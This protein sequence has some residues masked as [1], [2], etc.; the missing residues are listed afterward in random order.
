MEWTSVSNI[1]TGSLFFVA[2]HTPKFTKDGFDGLSSS[3]HPATRTTFD[4]QQDTPPELTK[5]IRTD[6]LQIAHVV[7]CVTVALTDLHSQSFG[8]PNLFPHNEDASNP[9]GTVKR[10]NDYCYNVHNI[11]FDPEGCTWDAMVT[12]STIY[13]QNGPKTNG[14]KAPMPIKSICQGKIPI[15]VEC[16]KVFLPPGSKGP[17]NFR[18]QTK[19]DSN[20]HYSIDITMI[21]K[22]E[23]RYIE[24]PIRIALFETVNR[25]ANDINRQITKESLPPFPEGNQGVTFRKI[26]QLNKKLK[27]GS[28]ATVCVGTHRKSGKKCAVKCVYRKKLTPNDDLTILSEVQIMSSVRHDSICPIVD[29]FMEEEC[30]FIVMPLMEGG[31]VFDRI[32]NLKKYDEN[33]ARNLCSNMIKAIAHLHENNIAHCDLKSRNLLLRSNEDATSVILADFGFAAKV[34]SPNSLTRQCGTPYFVAPEILL[35]NGYDTKSDMWSVGV[36]IYSLL[37]GGLPF[38]GKTHLDLFKAIVKGSFDFKDAHWDNVTSD[39]KDLIAKLLVTDPTKR[40]SAH[41][42]LRHSWIGAEANRLRRNSLMNTSTRLRTFNARLAFKT[43]ILATHSM[44]IWRNLV[45]DKKRKAPEGTNCV[46]ADSKDAGSALSNTPHNAHYDEEK[47]L[48]IEESDN[49]SNDMVVR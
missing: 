34:Y 49:D 22:K 19:D 27:S 6:N 20:M 38:T 29:F 10:D 31:D 5:N 28:F 41:D 44:I 8:R 43:A 16:T 1:E 23:L 48:G 42:A 7:E 17:Q 25:L 15:H 32:A 35:R 40:I 47:L 12:Y 14:Q 39:A 46:A 37:S 33:I 26:Y 9:N 45:R 11:V 4:P 21:L 24:K 36:I 3:L 2:R 18:Q 13:A 30:Y